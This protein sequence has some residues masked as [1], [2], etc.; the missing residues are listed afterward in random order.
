MN[1]ILYEEPTTDV[2]VIRCENGFLTVSGGG[3]ITNAI[4]EDYDEL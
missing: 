4:E 1:K 2:L 3:T